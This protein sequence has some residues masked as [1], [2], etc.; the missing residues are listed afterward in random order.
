MDVRVSKRRPR[1]SFLYEVRSFERYRC[2]E[3]RRAFWGKLAVNPEERARRKRQ[4]G[5]SHALQTQGRRRTIEIAL[6]IT[7]LL[8]FVM[9]IRYLI[10]RSDAP[11]PAG[12]PF[13]LLQN[14]PGNR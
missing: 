8:F 12:L 2:R 1:F 10:N 13:L 4:R 14:A 7:M 9:A 6:F 5:W 11:T 3:C